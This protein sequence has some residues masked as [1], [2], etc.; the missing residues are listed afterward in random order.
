MKLRTI[1]LI[2]VAILTAV[3]TRS[4]AADGQRAYVIVEGPDVLGEIDLSTGAFTLIGPNSATLQS[5]AI[6]PGGVLY[7]A[8]VS[9][10]V[11]RIDPSS[12]ALTLVA[13]SGVPILTL[14]STTDGRLW[15]MDT[16]GN[17]QRIDSETGLATLVGS[18]GICLACPT[19]QSGFLGGSDELRWVFSQYP[20]TP[21]GSNVYLL[22]QTSGAAT[23]IGP[24]GL[25]RGN[26]LGAVAGVSYV[27][28]NDIS[29]KKLY[30]IDPLTGAATF[31]TDLDTTLNTAL[32]V[33]VAPIPVP[34]PVTAGPTGP[35]GPPGPQGDPGPQ[36]PAGPAGP[37]GATGATG[38]HGPAGP[39]GPPGVVG[40]VGP[41][42]PIGP[43]GPPSIASVQVVTQNY[44]G[45]INL[46]C[47]AGYLVVAA[48]C[49]AGVGVVLHAQ[50]P[51]PPIGSWQHWLI[52]SATSPT[53]V[54]CSQL[55]GLQS[56]A[57][58]MCVK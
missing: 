20:F 52:P 31:V 16:S 25:D 6:G 38:P 55:G 43:P 46:S 42:G 12:G 5:I 34:A 13:N 44:S 15:A 45:T 2:V 58:L 51:P 23:L 41:Q 39:Q 24:T 1:A 56:Q 27:V 37:V 29:P 30:A 48:S 54:H 10:D 8:H 17:L 40:P 3:S 32:V 33:G 11:Y 53:G 47:P 19:S 18:T 21:N 4:E 57:Q 26:G 35:P 50:T 36:G 49:N 14:G 9:G 7:G 22:D 28:N